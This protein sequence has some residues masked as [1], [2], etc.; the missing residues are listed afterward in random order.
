MNEQDPWRVR[1][2]EDWGYQ[3]QRLIDAADQA[4][5]EANLQRQRLNEK[6]PANASWRISRAQLQEDRRLNPTLFEN[7]VRFDVWLKEKHPDADPEQAFLACTPRYYRHPGGYIPYMSPLRL[8]LKVGLGLSDPTPAEWLAWDEH[9][10]SDGDYT[11]IVKRTM[12]DA[13]PDWL[14]DDYRP[15]HGTYDP[16]Q[17]TSP[18]EDMG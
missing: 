11:Y 18:F 6:D 13:E 9:P 5:T 3:T 15:D 2:E 14:P 16:T 8:Y 7:A 12:K 1:E 17:F 4:G 10:I